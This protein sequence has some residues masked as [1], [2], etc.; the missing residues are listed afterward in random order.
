MPQLISAAL[1]QGDWLKFL[2]WPYHAKVINTLEPTSN[3]VVSS[4]G[5][6]IQFI[7]VY[8]VWSTNA[9]Q[10]N[11]KYQRCIG[12]NHAAGAAL[13]IGKRRGNDQRTL[14]AD[15]HAFNTQIPTLDHPPAAQREKERLTT[16]TRAV[17]FST[18]VVGCGCIV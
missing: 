5:C 16:I 1:Y 13:A 2:R 7:S 10:F 14:P 15:F 12:W 11:I 3:T 18:V 4:N 9:E 8:K 6:K 17:K